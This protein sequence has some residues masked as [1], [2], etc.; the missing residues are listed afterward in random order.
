[1]FFESHHSTEQNYFKITESD[2]TKSFS[3]H[4]HR[5]YELYAV[6]GGRSEAKIDGK[7]YTLLPG[8]AVLVFPYQRHEYNTEPNT[9]TTVCIFSPDLVGSF[10][11]H[12]Y[13]YLPKDNKFTFPTASIA[14]ETNLLK[15]KALC[16]EICGCFDECAEYEKREH[17][18]SDIITKILIFI[19]K[20]YQNECTLLTASQHVGYDYNYVSK[21]FKRAVKI[22]F[23][24]YVNNMRISEACRLLT[25]TDAS[26]QSIA[27][28]CGYTCT[29]TFHREFL[30]IMKTTPKKYRS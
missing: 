22:S 8:D 5:A 15:Q 27:E 24:A 11:R 23:N 7:S 9:A 21:I 4:I 3:L 16:Y 25:S 12:S 29:R 18:E 10:D 20:N 17:T 26:V 14:K 13:G 28:S 2:N 6:R 19:S 30:R 1:M